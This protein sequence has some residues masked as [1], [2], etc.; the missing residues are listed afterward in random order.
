MIHV[1]KWSRWEPN[2]HYTDTSWGAEVPSTMMSRRCERCGLVR[3][4]SRYGLV[5]PIPA[6]RR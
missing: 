5:I 2:Y 3:G 1:H 4:K 6:G